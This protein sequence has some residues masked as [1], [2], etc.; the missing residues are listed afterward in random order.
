[1]SQET[2]AWVDQR[3]TLVAGLITP[4]ATVLDLAAGPGLI[5]HKLRDPA[6]YVPVDFSQEALN[7]AGVPGI[8]AP[9]T[10]VPVANAAYHTVLA[11]EIL[12]HLD[13]PHPLVYEAIRIARVQVIFT[14]PNDRL[15]P[16]EFPYHRRTWT[17]AQLA[18]F[19]DTFQDIAFTTFLQA[20][21][22]IIGQ[23]IVH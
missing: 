23:C 20:P 7:L 19:L 9:C 16:H 11:M 18:D 5:R 3:L 15:P 4:K 10:D 2:D 17:Q 13:D 6:A 14:V 21:A 12:E 1:M 22:N 8:L